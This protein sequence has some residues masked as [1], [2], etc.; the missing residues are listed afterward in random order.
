MWR[1]ISSIRDSDLLG[2]DHPARRDPRFGRQAREPRSRIAAD[3]I[4]QSAGQRGRL[5]YAAFPA[6]H[7]DGGDAQQTGEVALA[8]A[9][10]H[11]ELRWELGILL[12]FDIVAFFV[13]VRRFEG[14]CATVGFLSLP[15]RPSPAGV[16]EARGLSNPRLI[17]P[18]PG[19]GVSI[20]GE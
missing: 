4:Q 15:H 13:F 6:L 14:R 10:L 1:V 18:P 5:A 11:A 7:E 19:A 16:A 20:V 2:A 9:G 3:Y 8:E 12:S 17:Q